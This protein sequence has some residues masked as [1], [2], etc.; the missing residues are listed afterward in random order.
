MM[1]TIIYIF[2]YIY[3]YANHPQYLRDKAEAE[4][5]GYGALNVLVDDALM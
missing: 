4:A 2:I 1:H 3:I 5:G